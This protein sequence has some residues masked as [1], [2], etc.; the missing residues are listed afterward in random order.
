MERQTPT[1]KE[2]YEHEATRIIDQFKPKVLETSVMTFKDEGMEQGKV[3]GP[4]YLDNVEFGWN[5]EGVAKRLAKVLNVRLVV[6]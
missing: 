4:I 3:I 5:Y 1:W 2:F 6:T